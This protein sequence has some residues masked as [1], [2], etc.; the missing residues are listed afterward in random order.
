MAIPPVF[1]NELR[2]RVSLSELIGRRVK[3]VRAG[4]EFKGCCPFHKEKSA[5]FT[6]NDDK[7]FYHCF[8]CG[9]HGDAIG[10]VMQHDNLSFIEAVEILAAQA[11][12]QVPQQSAQEVAQ[13][14]KQKDLYSLMNDATEYFASVLGGAEGRDAQKYL[15]DRQIPQEIVES[16]RLGFSPADGQALRRHLRAKDYTD[17]QMIEAGLIRRSERGGEPYAFFRDR[18]MFPVADRRGRVVAFGARVLPEYLRPL[19]PGAQTPPKY[20]NSID[21]PLFHKGRMLYG[22]AHARRAAAEGQKVIVVEGYLDVMAC[23]QAGLRGAVAPLGTAL[24]EEQ[25]VSLWRMIPDAS[26]VPVLCFDGDEAGRRAA[27]RA[28]ERILPLLQPDQSAVFAFLPEG[29]DPDSL[30]RTQGRKALDAVIDSALPLVDFLWNRHTAQQRFE[31]PEARAGLEKA[32]E[33][34][35]HKIADRSVQEYYRRAFKDRIFN[36]FRYKPAGGKMPYQGRGR[37]AKGAGLKGRLMP[38]LKIRRPAFAGG[39]MLAQ[40]ILLAAVINYPA[41]AAAV[42]EDLGRL[43]IP[44]RRLDQMRQ[45]ILKT[46]AE[47]PALDREGLLHHLEGEGFQEDIGLIHNESVYNHAGFAR[48]GGDERAALEGWRETW[49]FMQDKSVKHEIQSAGRVLAAETTPENEEKIIAL[50]DVHKASGD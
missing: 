43:H 34:E 14:R 8:G 33:D 2:N 15:S 40:R 48:S 32:L 19:Q 1:L 7:Q 44:D 21:T 10:F 16:F 17:E 25:I 35:A 27:A 24:T 23:F 5:S 4:R 37:G 29:Q 45:A 47:D 13:A 22:E 18:V 6:V 26:K 31:T 50:M 39:D 36:L 3:L 9:A 11:G 30:F 20:I 28:C 46:L 41:I 38:V 42:E 49:R 12:M